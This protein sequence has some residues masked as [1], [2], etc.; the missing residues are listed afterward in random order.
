M[1]V[2]PMARRGSPP[3][4]LLPLLRLHA[5][6]GEALYIAH[7]QLLVGQKPARSHASIVS[8]PAHSHS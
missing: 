1:T 3:A 6:D 8:G 5:A 7:K 2:S 4:G